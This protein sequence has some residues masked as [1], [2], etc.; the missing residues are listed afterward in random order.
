M[1]VSAARPHGRVGLSIRVKLFLA[2]G[3]VSSI[4]VAVCLFAGW[5]F[6]SAGSTIEVSG[7]STTSWRLPHSETTAWIIAAAGRARIAP[8]PPISAAP[9]SAAPNAKAGW[10]SSVRAVI[11]GA[12]R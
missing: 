6:S 7:L 3:A 5:L 12:R 10:M 4:T 2:F 8:I 11:R 9:A 1:N